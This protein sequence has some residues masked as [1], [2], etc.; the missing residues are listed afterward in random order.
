MCVCESTKTYMFQIIHLVPTFTPLHHNNKR[1]T[2]HNKYT[3]S[4]QEY[5]DLEVGELLLYLGSLL[6]VALNLLLE[7]LLPPLL[8]SAVHPVVD[9]LVDLVSF[10]VIGLVGAGGEEAT[11]VASK[12]GEREVAFFFVKT[13]SAKGLT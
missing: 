3:N 13:G 10:D 4:M 8:P 6:S 11:S 9:T 7:L 2:T 1:S 5:P 12:L